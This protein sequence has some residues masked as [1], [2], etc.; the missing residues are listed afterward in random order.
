MQLNTFFENE[1]LCNKSVGGERCVLGHGALILPP[2]QQFI[3][4]PCFAL[5]DIIIGCIPVPKLSELPRSFISSAMAGVVEEEL[6]MRARAVAGATQPSSPPQPVPCFGKR[7]TQRAPPLTFNT[8]LS[9]RWLEP[10][11]QALRDVFASPEEV[12]RLQRPTTR[13]ASAMPVRNG[14]QLGYRTLRR[15]DSTSAR[16]LDATAVPAYNDYTAFLRGERNV[17]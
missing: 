12:R 4:S 11:V 1:R 17:A 14:L 7:L 16:G 13:P 9:G 2:Q 5:A 10:E 8:S 3:E 15:I 6:R